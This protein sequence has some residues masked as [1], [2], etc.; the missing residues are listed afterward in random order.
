MKNQSVY[1]ICAFNEVGKE[2]WVRSNKRYN[3]ICK[4]INVY[5]TKLY[6]MCETMAFSVEEMVSILET[7]GCEKIG[8]P[9]T[10]MYNEI[11]IDFVWEFSC[12]SRCEFRA[13]KKDLNDKKYN[14]DTAD[15]IMKEVFEKTMSYYNK[16]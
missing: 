9:L 16:N 13:M 1:K 8:S 12:N 5:Q 10:G 11:D 14:N 6:N 4:I 15:K 3:T 2:I 7:F